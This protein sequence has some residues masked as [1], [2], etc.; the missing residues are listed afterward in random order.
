MTS[1]MA[2]LSAAP[3]L[4]ARI[5]IQVVLPPSATADDKRVAPWE[6]PMSSPSAWLSAG[7]GLLLAVSALLTPDSR[8]EVKTARTAPGRAS[9]GP[10]KTSALRIDLSKAMNVNLP[11]TSRDFEAASFGTPD[12]KS[13]WVLRLPGGRPIATPAYAD[14]ML[15]VG[16]GYGSHEFYALDS[17]TGRV[18]WK[19]QT[20]DDG[21][22]AAVGADG[23]GALNT[24]SCPRVVGEGSRGRGIWRG[25]VGGSLV[26][27]ETVY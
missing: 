21:P 1:A 18:I 5:S 9:D 24:R 11:A 4:S 13:G 10:V 7:V 15:F 26:G 23:R 22:T 20:G 27:P 12:G 25:R 8:P 17:E 2:G 3:I 14:G 6:V 16:G 19:L